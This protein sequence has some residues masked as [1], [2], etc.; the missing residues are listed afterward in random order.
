MKKFLSPL[1]LKD[2]LTLTGFIIIGFGW[3]LIDQIFL[4]EAYQRIIAFIILI[5]A[6]YY[7][8][9]AL[10]KPINVMHYANSIALITVSF[11]VIVSLVMH[12]I[13]NNDFSRKS[14]LI[15][16]ITGLLPYFCGFLY[17]LTKKK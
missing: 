13:I 6:L 11:T 12:V 2:C 9:Y 7:L 10:N 4:P 8:Q 16:L 15:W 17:M 5:F 3:V 1:K 14:L